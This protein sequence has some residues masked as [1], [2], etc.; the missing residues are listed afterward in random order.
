MEIRAGKAVSGNADNWL[1]MIQSP[2]VLH[3]L[4]RRGK[5]ET[6]SNNG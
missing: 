4:G 6:A 2:A 3:Y 5:W 1:L